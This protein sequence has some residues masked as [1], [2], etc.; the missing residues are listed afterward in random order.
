MKR[1]F[2][3]VA[4]I[5]AGVSGIA[6]AVKLKQAGYENFTVF[7][8]HS[9]P[10][11][12]WFANT[13]PGCAV[14]VP[15]HAYSF[16]FMPYDWKRT[17]ADQSENLQYLRDTI[18]HFN[19]WEKFQFNTTVKQAIWDDQ[20]CVYTLYFDSGEDAEFDIVVSCVGLLSN[21]NYPAWPGLESF[22]GPR[23]HTSQWDHGL[24]LSGKKVAVVGTGSTAAQLV[25]ALSQ[26]AG[27]VVLFQR[28]PGWVLRK[29]V[30]EFTPEERARFRKR[31]INQKIARLKIFR[32]RESPQF[33]KGIRVAESPVNRELR[34]ECEAFIKSTINDPE[35]QRLVTPD[36]PVGCKR[37]ILDS[38]FYPSLNNDNVTLVP[39]EV[40]SVTERGIVDAT[41]AHHD[42]DVIVMAT[43][44]TAAR[45][46]ASLEVQGS[47]KRSIQE[48]WGLS[49]RA[50]C[51]MTVPGIPNFFMLYGPNTNGAV[52]IMATST[53]QAVAVVDCIKR[54]ERRNCRKFDTKPAALKKWIDYVDEG[55][56]K[57]TASHLTYCTNYYHSP[58]GQNVTQFPGIYAIFALF[59]KF[60]FPRGIEFS[61]GGMSEGPSAA[62]PR[63]TSGRA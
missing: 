46:L 31:V 59:Q 54:M 33:V 29:D 50:L 21:P 63:V 35:V 32:V 48:I 17:H 11:G 8:R 16:S 18:M 38:D 51:G 14:D 36:T 30:R 60:T 37:P 20:R 12:T 58:E 2:T 7:E 13:Y 45:F 53:R 1:R 42:V 24:D 41:G 47:N 26:I 23:F 52:S 40:E 22:K 28:S 43:G 9:G 15:S 56:R 19:L 4:V 39:H 5:G 61:N 44:F 10:G 27:Q 57:R 6:T 55:N 3:R 49:P 62:H 25:P 34:E